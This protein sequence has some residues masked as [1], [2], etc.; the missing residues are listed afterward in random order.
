MRIVKS[1]TKQHTTTTN[2]RT[3][4]THMR[5]PEGSTVRSIYL[6]LHHRLLVILPRTRRQY[7]LVGRSITPNASINRLRALSHACP[8][9]REA[10]V[11]AVVLSVR[12]RGFS[13]I[14]LTRADNPIKKN[15]TT[16]KRT[17]PFLLFIYFIFFSLVLYYSIK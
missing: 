3:V 10:P 14:F 4:H 11:N 16:A 9:P 7:L 15:K 2:Q 1:G 17:L 13:H 12:E 8:S 5:L 6:S